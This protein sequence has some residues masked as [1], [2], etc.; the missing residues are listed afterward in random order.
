MRKLPIAVLLTVLADCIKLQFICPKE[1][2]TEDRA[3]RGRRMAQPVYCMKAKRRQSVKEKGKKEGREEKGRCSYKQ[4]QDQEPLGELSGSRSF[5]NFLRCPHLQR[6]CEEQTEI[7]PV[8][9]TSGLV[10]GRS[11]R[12]GKL[13]K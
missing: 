12:T 11:H 9:A 10:K 8:P 7:L 1:R 3:E 5:D 2:R 4:E 13:T 6:P